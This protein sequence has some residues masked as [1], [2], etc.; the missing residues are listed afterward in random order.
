[1]IMSSIIVTLS[2][3]DV[4]RYPLLFCDTQSDVVISSLVALRGN[5]LYR[6]SHTHSHFCTYYSINH[7]SFF[8]DRALV[9][10][11][12]KGRVD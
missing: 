11:I 12:A 10:S 3:V 6:A 5:L 2:S 4:S 9:G 8:S 7:M 1:M